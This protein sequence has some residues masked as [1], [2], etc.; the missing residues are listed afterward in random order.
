MNS[1]IKKSIAVSIAIFILLVAYYGSYLPMRKSMVFIETMQSSYKIKTTGDFESIFSV[2]LDYSS[3]IGQEELVRNMANTIN[4]SLQGVSD[5][6][7]VGELVNYAEKYF[8][9]IIAR[10][11]GMSFGQDVYILGMIN[12]VAFLK[13]KEPKYLQAAEKYFKMEQ[14]LGPKRPQGLYGLFDVYRLGGNVDEFKKIADQIL[15]Q[16]PNDARI[17]TMINQALK[18]SSSENK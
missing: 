1:D 5:P 11:R 9:P 16:W 17:S 3:P 2:P 8:G 18:S 14:V 15:S 12:E 6:R 10:G 7:A 4:G 13:T